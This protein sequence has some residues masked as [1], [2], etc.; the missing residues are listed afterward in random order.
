MR[1]TFIEAKKRIDSLKKY[2]DLLSSIK[3]VQLLETTEE[4]N[5]SIQQ[6]NQL[7]QQLRSYRDKKNYD[8][9]IVII[10]L[11]GILENYIEEIIIAYLACLNRVIK[12]YD[13]LPQKIKNNHLELSANL[14]KYIKTM[15]KYENISQNDV[16]KNLNSCMNSNNYRLNYLAF[17]YHSSNFRQDSIREI[18]NNM[19]IND[20]LTQV[21]DKESF[22]EYY[23]LKEGID[24]E[25][26]KDIPISA[27]F[28][29]VDELAK[30]RNEIAHGIITDDI[31]S[32]DMLK[33][34]VEYIEV[35]VLGIYEVVEEEFN[36]YEF[37]NVNKISLGR[38]IKVFNNEIIGI[39]LQYASIRRGDWI[40]AYSEAHR[41]IQKGRVI[42]LQIEGEEIQETPIDADIEVGIKVDFKAK[43]NREYYIAI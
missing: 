41:I 11:Y 29:K 33:D 40:F 1:A 6:V 21:K 19:E 8:Y 16:I 12:D 39:K 36:R 20:I 14:I 31:L 9:N 2:L 34:Y 35:I 3:Q 32:L 24:E 17:T 30:R 42:S 4:N 7:L 5:V 10:T 38:P 22:S 18:F 37:E 43:E 28:D 27:L 15:N 13:N 23:A 25:N 26:I